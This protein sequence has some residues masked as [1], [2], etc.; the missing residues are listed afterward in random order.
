MTSAL[1]GCSILRSSDKTAAVHD[2][3][4]HSFGNGPT[5]TSR[6][7]G[8]APEP[9]EQKS[10]ISV[11]WTYPPPVIHN[12]VAYLA[13]D[14]QIV[15]VATDGSE[16]WSRRLHAE[17]SGVPAIDPGRRRL[18]VPIKDVSATSGG[19]VLA[20]VIAFSLADGDI[21]NTLRVGE[22]TAFGVT[23]ADGDVF[24]RSA[25][26]CVRFGPD[27]TERWRHPL[28][29]LGAGTF[30]W[31]SPSMARVAPAVAEDG[32]YV[33]DRHALVKLDPATGNVR[34]RVTVDVPLA[35]SIVD[36]YGAI[37]TG[38]RETVAVDHSGEVRWRRNLHSRAAAAAGDGDVY[39]VSTDLHELD[40][41]TGETT[42]QAHLPDGET[43]PVV[44]DEDVLVVTG[45]DI[46]AFRRN[47]GGILRPD[48]ERWRAS[49][50]S[51]N[52]F[53]SPVVAA[54]HVFVIGADSLL[55]LRSGADS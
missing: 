46:R 14:H 21:L 36:E 45:G 27:G 53:A 54:G 22:T 38:L 35:A 23:V 39:V 30:G 29:S 12:G 37:Q 47:A 51:A 28:A 9:D 55:A 13:T 48:R 26:A 19:P 31:G 5:N 44:T 2:G 10:L 50:V 3:N 20:S 7:A 41:V 34:W 42:W 1:A 33:P 16:Q 43:E 24:I 25:S 15:A 49:S 8:G 18:Y 32:I 11:E 52:R 40:A 4:W 6:V 17:V